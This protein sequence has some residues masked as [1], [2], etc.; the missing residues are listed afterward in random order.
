MIGQN[1]IRGCDWL[2]EITV[3]KSLGPL[4]KSSR[5]VG[6]LVNTHTAGPKAVTHD[7]IERDHTHRH[8]HTNTMAS[9]TVSLCYAKIHVNINSLPLSL[10]HKSLKSPLCHFISLH[11]VQQHS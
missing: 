3:T 11:T 9:G 8:T 6:Q 4:A 7:L 1:E 10:T 2:D 5:N